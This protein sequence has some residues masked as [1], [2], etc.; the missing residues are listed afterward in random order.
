MK[1]SLL[2]LSLIASFSMSA[3]WTE[4]GPTFEDASRGL[5]EIK[6]VDANT[7]WALGYDGTTANE[8]I[9]EC[10]VTSDGGS[11][12]SS[13]VME[14]GNPLLQINN[15][16][17]VSADVAWISALVPDDGFGNVY[18]T[19]DGGASWN[20]TSLDNQ[21]FITPGTSFLN[22]VYFWNANIG[23]AY[24]DP[25]GTG[26]NRKFEIWRTIDGGVTWTQII[27]PTGTGQTGNPLANEY[28]YNTAPDVRGNTLWFTTDAG[29]LIK[30]TDMGLTWFGYNTPLANFG[31]VSATT[32]N[33]TRG[34]V[35]FSDENT[36]YLLKDV[37]TGTATNRV[38][39][40][41][42]YTTTNGG[43]TWST[44]LP[45]TGTRTL[46]NYIPGT[47]IMVGTSFGTPTGNSPATPVGTSI[48]YDNGN[49][50]TDLEP[51]G[52]TQRGFTD[53]LSAS[54]GWC[55]GFSSSTDPLESKGV[56]KLSGP[57]ETPAVAPVA[58]FKV[59]PNPA[60]STVNISAADV[61][62]Y[63]LSVTDLSG[64]IVMTKSLNGIENTIDVSSLSSG[65][66]FFELTSDSK[67]EVI[68]ILKN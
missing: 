65:A 68:K 67:R 54:V 16:S 32:G 43:Q 40:R 23:V 53:F 22:G 28:G 10:T 12:W 46:L 60:T 5:V 66:Y 14:L 64:K 51:G 11:N 34:D 47:T 7:V 44:A 24:G 56:Y 59:Y 27:T 37:L 58:K 31:G 35:Y 13:N 18:K 17:P 49:N 20:V 30:T 42:F 1:K 48:S 62:S 19:E 61:D 29:R 3:Q 2:F 33:G 55:G 52:T 15:I 6:I 9:Q 8:D 38:H 26:A 39:T 21:G 57:L 50:W 36:G 63:K 25:I 4:Q 41:T 45:F